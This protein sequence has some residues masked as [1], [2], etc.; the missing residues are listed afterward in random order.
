MVCLVQALGYS[1]CI[2]QAMLRHLTHMAVILRVTTAIMC[3]V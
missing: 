3:Y 1:K 2:P